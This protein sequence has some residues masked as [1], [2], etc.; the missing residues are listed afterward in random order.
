MSKE[1]GPREKAL[2]EM[3][4]ARYARA[5]ELV[6]RSAIPKPTK[7]ALKKAIAEAS[8]KT[9]KGRKKK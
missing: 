7:A 9:G 8:K 3:R 1:A 4:E 2:R 6:E 5:T